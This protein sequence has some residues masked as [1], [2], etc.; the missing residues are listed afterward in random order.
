MGV[1]TA[2]GGGGGGEVSTLL[3]YNNVGLKLSAMRVKLNDRL[4]DSVG[5]GSGGGGGNRAGDQ[6]CGGCC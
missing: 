5:F 4:L 2:V 3:P 1:C 6:I